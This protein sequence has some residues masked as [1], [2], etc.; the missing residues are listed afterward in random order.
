VIEGL[1]SY[2]GL[3]F[4]CAVSGTFVPVPEDVPLLYAGMRIAEGRWAWAPTLAAALAGVA[5]RDLAAYGLGRLL[6]AWLLERPWMG[7]VLG[8]K[9][10]ARAHRMVEDH[11][12]AAVLAGRFFV[13]MR[14]SV[15]LVAGAMGLPLRRFALWDGV[16][17]L[18]AVPLAVWLGFEVGEPVVHGIQTVLHSSRLLALTFVTGAL[19]YVLS[20]WRRRVRVAQADG[21]P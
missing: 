17:L 5:V 20:A 12:A 7:R 4:V 10:L 15:F 1:D 11:G 21:Q 19:V 9:R 13:G 6:G 8:R 16:G 2:P 18:V 14:A 3:F